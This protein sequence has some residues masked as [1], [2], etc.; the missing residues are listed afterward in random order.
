MFV[1][2]DSFPRF[3]HKYFM[4]GSIVRLFGGK[5]CGRSCSGSV[6]VPPWSIASRSEANAA[7]RVGRPPL[8]KDRSF[9][10]EEIYQWLSNSDQTL[11]IAITVIR[12]ISLLKIDEN[13]LALCCSQEKWRG[14]YGWPFFKAAQSKKKHKVRVDDSILINLAFC[15]LFVAMSQCLRTKYTV[16]RLLVTVY[17]TKHRLS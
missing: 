1:D 16:L 5:D 12:A 15:Y 11:S 10:L 2:T 3:F 6:A 17:Q 4:G 8:E 9:V 7:S 13:Y 14:I